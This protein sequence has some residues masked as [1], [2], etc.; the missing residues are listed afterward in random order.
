M[1]IA[2]DLLGTSQAG[3]FFLANK[4]IQARWKPLSLSLSV[5][6]FSNLINVWVPLVDLEDHM[7]VRPLQLWCQNTKDVKEKEK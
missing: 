1:I 5:C 3:L 4:V 2:S 7:G 6:V